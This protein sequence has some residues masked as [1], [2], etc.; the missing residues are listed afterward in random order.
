MVKVPFGIP[1][2]L[3]T[4]YLRFRITDGSRLHGEKMKKWETTGGFVTSVD[5]SGGIIIDIN[6]LE[7]QRLIDIIFTDL[8]KTCQ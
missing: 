8:S 1:A 6:R 2:L 3:D 7:K 5:G 4:F